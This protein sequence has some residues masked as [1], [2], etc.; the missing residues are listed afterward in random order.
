MRPV[1]LT[2][3]VICNVA[4]RDSFVAARAFGRPLSRVQRK[5]DNSS[6]RR[7]PSMK[8]SFQ[9]NSCIW[10]VELVDSR[11]VELLYCAYVQPHNRRIKN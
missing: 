7:Q 1:C 10:A 9:G 6:K 2:Q 3:C 5:L 8:C 4:S 11:S